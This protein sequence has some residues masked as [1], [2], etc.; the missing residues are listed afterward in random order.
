MGILCV[1]KGLRGGVT[2]GVPLVFPVAIP[3]AKDPHRYLFCKPLVF[4]GKELGVCPQCA[5]ARSFSD[6]FSH[7]AIGRPVVNKQ[8]HTMSL[9]EY[10]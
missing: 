1:Y 8:L 5:L 9:K 2:G 10:P 4:K 3:P 6:T 7:S